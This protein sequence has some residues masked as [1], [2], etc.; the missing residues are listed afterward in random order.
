MTNAK[1]PIIRPGQ[2]KPYTKAT[3]KELEQRLK[4]AAFLESLEWAKADIDWFFSEIF[5]IESRQTARYRAHARA[6]YP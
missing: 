3:R 5:G 6:R 4:A 1:H 2:F